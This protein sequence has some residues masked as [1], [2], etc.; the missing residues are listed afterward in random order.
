MR[1]VVQRVSRASVAVEGAVVGE[2]GRGLL[3]LVG[4]ADG[5]TADDAAAAAAKIAGLRI[6]GDEEGRVNRSVGEVGGAVLVVSQ[7]TLLA[8]VRKGRRP[9]FGRAA[10]PEAAEPLVAAVAAGLEQHGLEVAHGS[11]GASMQVSLVND[12]PVTV[13]LDVGGGRVS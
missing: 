12:G 2:I 11:F 4:V 10:H 3:L 13:V 6:F 5:D 8:D 7:F 9:S 1:V